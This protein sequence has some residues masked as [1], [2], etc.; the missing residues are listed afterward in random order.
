M[1]ASKDPSRIEYI[2]PATQHIE[3][4]GREVCRELG[5]EFAQPEIVE[6]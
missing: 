4:Y 5:E 2:P 6:E 1:N 3:T